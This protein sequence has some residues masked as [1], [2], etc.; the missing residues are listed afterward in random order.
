MALTLLQIAGIGALLGV[1]SH[2]AYF[3][4]GEHHRQS[5]EYFIAFL[6]F[7]IVAA[8]LLISFGVPIFLALQQTTTFYS[9]YLGG[10]YTSL[11][12][13][14]LF[15]HRLHHFPGPFGAKAGGLWHVA[16]LAGKFDNYKHLGR[17]HAKYGDFVRVGQW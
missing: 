17:M 6:G 12:I 5:F 16:H 11:L 3:K 13:Y 4:H 9:C 10:I 1:I 2:Q 7:P 8:G 15:F 14:R